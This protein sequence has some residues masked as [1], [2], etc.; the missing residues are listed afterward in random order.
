MLEAAGVDVVLTRSVDAFVNEPPTERTG[1]GLIDGDDELAARPD[2]ANAARADL[3]IAIHNN[4]AVN[5]SVGGPSTYYFDER[6]FGARSARLARIVQA[7]M[8][9]A[10]QGVAD[11]YQ[12]YDHGT[13]IYPYY[14]LRGVDP[15]RLEPAH[16]DAG[17][18]Q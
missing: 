12:P 16:A 6:P 17:R 1:D 18:A 2:I 3:F 7:E 5:E 8:M 9:S 4:I 15:P 14:V 10:L 11:G 13:L